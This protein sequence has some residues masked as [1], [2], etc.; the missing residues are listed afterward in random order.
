ML[1]RTAIA[2]LALA[3]FVSA[4][5]ITKWNT[6][7]LNC[8]IN[9]SLSPPEASR[10]LAMLHVAQFEAAN[11]VVD[12]Y[13]PYLVESG[14]TA[15]ASA[16]PVAAAAQAAHDVMVFLYPT[17][18]SDWDLELAASLASYSGAELT[19]SIAIGAATA[20]AIIA[21]RTGDGSDDA[22][23][24][25]TLPS[26]LDPGV[27]RPTPPA[28]AAYLL[29]NWRLVKTWGVPD[30]EEIASTVMPPELFSARYNEEVDLVR[31]LGAASDSERSA[32]QSLIARVW[33]AGDGTVTPP[34]QWFQIAQQVSG[35]TSMPFMQESQ[36]F[37]RLGMAVADAAIVCWTTKFN[38]QRWRPY[39]A[40]QYQ[41]LTDWTSYITTP[42]SP[43]HTSGHATFS[44]AAATVLRLQT[45][46]NKHTTFTVEAG[47][48]SPDNRTL[49]SLAAAAEEAAWSRVY[50]GIHFESDSIDGL[51]TGEEIGAFIATYVIPL[52]GSFEGTT[53]TGEAS[54][55]NSTSSDSG[56]N[57]TSSDSAATPTTVTAP[58]TRSVGLQIGMTFGIVGIFLVMILY[59]TF[60]RT[61]RSL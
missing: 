48:T 24:G 13:A 61:Q 23:L 29:P 32:T 44:G 54:D 2:V 12:D 52:K 36:T 19:D 21:N 49:T 10:Q 11:T 41:N 33:A 42:P 31:R 43:A 30:R 18:Q 17:A 1:V 55:L 25:W 47:P 15:G 16:N 20:A 5:E 45:G 39:S 35:S 46:K 7:L 56:L 6:H 14:L 26:S 4:S 50:G 60:S 57:S 51:T 53:I 38:S 58:S 40:I 22:A 34:G 37:A 8:F 28:D 27:W 59:W 9:V 3:A